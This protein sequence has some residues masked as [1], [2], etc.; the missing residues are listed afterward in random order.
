MK[1]LVTS[2]TLIAAALGSG[3][4]LAAQDEHN[5]NQAQKPGAVADHPL[6][7]EHG[8]HAQNAQGHERMAQMHARMSERM[9]QHGEDERDERAHGKHG[10]H[11]K[12][13]ENCPMHKQH[14]AS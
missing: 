5:H 8:G 14:K 10:S 11:G 2:A 6:R 7:D 9:A 13:G 1:K 12:T 3:V 4:I